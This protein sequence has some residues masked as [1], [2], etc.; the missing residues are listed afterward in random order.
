VVGE[1]VT[2]VYRR[3]RGVRVQPK[4]RGG[5]GG[6]R[7]KEGDLRLWRKDEEGRERQGAPRA[8]T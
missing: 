6:K 3:E 2:A 1:Y 4:R 5:K 7:E 8:M